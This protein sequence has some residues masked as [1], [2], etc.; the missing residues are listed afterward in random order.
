MNEYRD[1]KEGE[2]LISAS[3]ERLKIK[4]GEFTRTVQTPTASEWIARMRFQD[5]RAKYAYP[6]ED[7]EL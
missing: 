4:T 7:I 5:L 2:I 6:L 1:W 3:M